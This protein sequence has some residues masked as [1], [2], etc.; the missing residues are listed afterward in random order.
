[1]DESQAEKTCKDVAGVWKRLFEEDPIGDIDNADRDTFVYWMQV[2]TSGIY[3]DLRLPKESLILQQGSDNNVIKKNP[4]SLCGRSFQLKSNVDDDDDSNFVTNEL[5]QVLW[6]QKSFAGKLTYA[7]GD[8]S[9]PPNHGAALKNDPTLAQHVQTLPDTLCTCYWKRH[10]DYQPPTGG[11]DIGICATDP[12]TVGKKENGDDTDDSITIRE[13]GYDGS[14]AEGWKR[15]SNT[16]ATTTTTSSGGGGPFFAMEL[17]SENGHD[18]VGYWIRV[19]NY[20]GYVVGRPTTQENSQKLYCHADSYKINNDGSVVGKV[21][22]DAIETLVPLKSTSASSPDSGHKTTEEK[23]AKLM[24]DQLSIVGSYVC[25]MGHVNPPTNEGTKKWKILHSTHPELVGCYLLGEN[26]SSTNDYQTS[27]CCS[28]CFIDAADND[29]GD[30]SKQLQVGTVLTQH[31][32][33]GNPP[34]MTKSS[35]RIVRKWKVAEMNS[36]NDD[37]SCD[38]HLC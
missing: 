22:K 14:Y 4:T 7:K 8:V 5:L 12:T 11:L 29:G 28:T 6:K 3:V 25:V 9:N 34:L 36:D 31:V 37:T 19:G 1:M 2:P 13:T 32:V 26:E 33:T 10:I 38:I 15:L 24:K 27:L 21:L 20:F 16:A 23:Q 35:T 18:R 30:G 17:L